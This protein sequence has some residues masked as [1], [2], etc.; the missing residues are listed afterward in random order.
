M[1]YPLL[2]CNVCNDA[3]AEWVGRHNDPNFC[4]CPSCGRKRDQ[5]YGQ[6]GVVVDMA[7]TRVLTGEDAVSEIDTM[8]PNYAR[9]VLPA[10]LKAGGADVANSIDTK[11]GKVRHVNQAAAAKYRK[12]KQTLVRDG[13]IPG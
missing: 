12:V 11:T 7:T 9:K 8:T 2:P 4:K 10:Y 6:K 1:I 5:D 13:I 3:T